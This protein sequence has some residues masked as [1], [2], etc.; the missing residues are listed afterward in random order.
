[1]DRERGEDHR[2]REVVVGYDG[3]T[4]SAVALEWAAWE[5]AALGRR[6]RILTAAPKLSA[7][8]VGPMARSAV[9]TT[10]R[11]LVGRALHDE[12]R[13]IASKYLDEWA[14]R[15]TEVAGSASAALVWASREAHMLVLGNR[16]FGAYGSALLGSV[17]SAVA[18]HAECPVTVV[19]GVVE[20]PRDRRAVTV[21]VDYL[22]P[23]PATVRFAAAQASRWGVS[24][25][26]VSAWA[27]P[28]H[29]PEGTAQSS[30]A[31]VD[32]GASVRF[33]LALTAIRNASEQARLVDGDLAIEARTSEASA[34]AALEDD[35]RRSSLV[36]L[37]ARRLEPRES[38]VA[39]SVS[40]TLLNHASCPVTIAP[41]R[42]L[43]VSRSTRR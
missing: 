19:R 27:P 37:G 14:V 24:L 11:P 25:R 35:S 20:D 3:S 34:A 7:Q 33:A 31:E 23:S 1:M 4:H 5:A 6:L 12:G 41:G 10:A 9:A 39:G 22:A 42:P 2:L 28:S 29:G 36:V 38:M 32:E 13:R 17:S 21:G 40:Y 30:A 15:E 18:R 43:L 8:A 16:G 26:I